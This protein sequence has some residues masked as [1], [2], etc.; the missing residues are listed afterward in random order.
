MTAENGPKNNLIAV[1]S[2]KGGVGKTWFAITLAHALA[3]AGR[4]VLLFDG[5]LG[6][7]NIDIQLGLMPKSD[8]GQAIAGK[9]RLTRCI[10]RYPDGNFDVLAGRS[11]S[12]SL[13]SLPQ[14]R[15][16]RLG[17]ELIAIAGM[18]DHVLVDLGAGVDRTVQSLAAM[19]GRALLLVNDEPTS[20]TDGY[21]FLKLGWQ[22]HPDMRIDVVVNS[23]DSL[24]KGR[25]TF[26]KLEKSSN[27]FL[28]RVPALLGVVRRDNKVRDAIR[29]QSLLI[30]RSPTSDAAG[31]VEK[32]ADA[33]RRS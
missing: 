27:A 16:E 26:T 21:A 32:I 17:R 20:L 23:A 19:A 10:E 12:G 14:P 13:A 1:A 31:D 15:I 33:I 4:K 29:A 2:G 22:A 30:T 28:K 3:R 18:Y 11:G 7:A 24:D 8:V 6:L 25:A 5:D 9:T